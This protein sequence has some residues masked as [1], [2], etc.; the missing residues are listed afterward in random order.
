[1]AHILHAVHVNKM[2]IVDRFVLQSVRF[3]FIRCAMCRIEARPFARLLASQRKRQRTRLR[4]LAFDLWRDR[5]ASH[6][7]NDRA[8]LTHDLHKQSRRLFSTIRHWG[9]TTKYAMK[10]AT[11]FIV[12]FYLWRLGRLVAYWRHHVRRQSWLRVFIV[13]YRRRLSTR[14]LQAWKAL[15]MCQDRVGSILTARLHAHINT[16]AERVLQRWHLEALYMY[17]MRIL[18]INFINRAR[19]Q[20]CIAVAQLCAAHISCP[21]RLPPHAHTPQTQHAALHPGAAAHLAPL[22]THR[23][24]LN[25]GGC[26]AY[27]CIKASHSCCLC[28]QVMARALSVC[29]E[30]G[31]GW[32]AACYSSSGP[33][34]MDL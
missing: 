30:V 20:R 22:P 34:R 7:F 4:T 17:R 5:L 11:F 8:I 18:T 26:W 15:L 12:K 9:L 19:R 23:A 24:A 29:K 25:C 16:P 3:S 13:H 10:V 33:L 6:Y 2:M 28:P 14:I 32:W 1:M 27:G 31:H 21:R